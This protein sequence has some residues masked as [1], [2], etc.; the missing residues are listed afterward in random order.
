MRILN[1]EN[2]IKPILLCLSSLPRTYTAEIILLDITT[3][4]GMLATTTFRR[5]SNC[6]LQALKDCSRVHTLK[7]LMTI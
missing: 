3:L 6:R 5:D 1:D 7:F 2:V 4:V